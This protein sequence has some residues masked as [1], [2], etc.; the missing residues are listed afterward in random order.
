MYNFAD[1][2]IG[3]L[4]VLIAFSIALVGILTVLNLRLAR[5]IEE[6]YKAAENPQHSMLG[7]RAEFPAWTLNSQ[8][9]DERSRN[10]A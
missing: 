8:A 3:L 1:M 4:L 5:S 10:T 2:T 9:G 7:A 6:E